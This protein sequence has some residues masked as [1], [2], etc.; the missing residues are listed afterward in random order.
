[1]YDASM[2][3]ITENGEQTKLYETNISKRILDV[4]TNYRKAIEEM[5]V[6]HKSEIDT[7]KQE[8]AAIRK[9]MNNIRLLIE[10]KLENIKLSNEAVEASVK[11]VATAEFKKPK[12]SVTSSSENNN[13]LEH[14]TRNWC[15]HLG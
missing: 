3:K 8:N 5:E 2:A 7:L 13:K 9:E 1:M 11:H 15:V 4:E 14:Y 10:G 6:R 12:S